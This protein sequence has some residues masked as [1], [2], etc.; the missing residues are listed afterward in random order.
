[1]RLWFLLKVTYLASRVYHPSM[2]LFLGEVNYGASLVA[3][4]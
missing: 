2:Y 4:W 1:M 3:Q